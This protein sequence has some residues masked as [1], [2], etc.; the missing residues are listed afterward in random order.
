MPSERRTRTSRCS[1]RRA[2]GDALVIV[3]D[4]VQHTVHMNRC[5]QCARAL[6]CCARASRSST[7]GQI[8]MSPSCTASARRLR[9]GRK[10]Q[11]VGRVVAPTVAAI[12][13]CGCAPHRRSAARARSRAHA[14]PSAA[15]AQRRSAA[16][17]GT[18][19][20]RVERRTLSASGAHGQQACGACSLRV[21]IA[22]AAIDR[23]RCRCRCHCRRPHRPARC[24]APADG[25]PHRRPQND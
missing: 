15:T 18:Q 21:F 17:P 2:C 9:G 16:A 7:C 5:V 25:A 3:A 20:C 4:Q 14:R 10:R 19:P 12:E 11:H 8:T 6:L 1:M 13:A 22:R 23:C 24:V